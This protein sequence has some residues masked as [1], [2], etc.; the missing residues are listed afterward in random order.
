MEKKQESFGNTSYQ[1]GGNYNRTD[2]HRAPR[3][4]GYGQGRGNQQFYSSQSRYQQDYREFQQ[5]TQTDDGEPICF[6]CRQPGH[7]ARGCRV[8][9]DHSRRGL[10]WNRPSSRGRR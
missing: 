2:S 4:R 3:G 9:L 1:Q 10:N 5:P 6:R 7:L 8:I